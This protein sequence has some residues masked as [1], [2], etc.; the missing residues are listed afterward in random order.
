[1]RPDG[2]VDAWR[3]PHGARSTRRAH[4]VRLGG[5]P[6]LR[7]DALVRVEDPLGVLRRAL[8]GPPRGLPRP[9]GLVL[10]RRAIAFGGLAL[11]R[12]E[13]RAAIATLAVT[14]EGS[15]KVRVVQAPSQV[16]RDHLETVR[17]LPGGG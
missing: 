7:P 4:C 17:T 13:A 11:Q 12:R 14:D 16:Q 15:I 1:M 9:V 3:A 5:H 10:V 8:C 2:W 6:Q